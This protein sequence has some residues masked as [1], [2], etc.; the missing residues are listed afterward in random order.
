MFEGRTEGSF[1]RALSHLRGVELEGL[2]PVI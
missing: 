1:P 2:P